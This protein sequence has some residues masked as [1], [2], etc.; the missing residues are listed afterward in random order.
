MANVTRNRS[1]FIGLALTDLRPRHRVHNEASDLAGELDLGGLDLGRERALERLDR[2]RPSGLRVADEPAD[3]LLRDPP[4][5][6]KRD[7]VAVIR[8]RDKFL[9]TGATRYARHFDHL[10][11]VKNFDR[12]FFPL[13]QFRI[14]HQAPYIVRVNAYIK[15]MRYENLIF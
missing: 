14:Y 8:G 10:L 4:S 13:C 7:Q 1:F 2:H 15:G 12:V 6:Q 3:V 11:F 9:P 5:R